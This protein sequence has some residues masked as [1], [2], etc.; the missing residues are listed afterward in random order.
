MLF[1]IINLT[2]II[3]SYNNDT[4]YYLEPVYTEIGTSELLGSTVY[5]LD[6]NYLSLLIVVPRGEFVMLVAYYLSC[7]MECIMSKDL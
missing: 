1:Y 4:P 3:N 2:T 5:Q 7:L 6:P